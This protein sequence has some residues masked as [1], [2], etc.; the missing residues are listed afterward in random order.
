MSH[1]SHDRTLPDHPATR[2]WM[3]ALVCAGFIAMVVNWFDI[4]TGFHA[5]GDEYGLAIPD[6]AFLISMFVAAYGLLHI[7]GGFLATRW[8]LRR[9]IAVGLTIEGIGAIGSASAGSFAQLVMW[10]ALAG[11]GASI[12]AAVGIAAVSIWFRERHHGLAL[13]ISSAAFSVGT[14]LGL[15]TWADITDA[16][17]WR[18]AVVISGALAL[19]VAALSLLFFR[20]PRGVD[21]LAGVRLTVASLKETL[22]NRSIWIFGFAFFGA[23]GSFLAASQLL[24]DYG[25][26]RAIGSSE[27]GFAAFLIGIAGVPGSIAAGWITDRYLSPRILFIAGATLEAVFLAAVPLSGPGTFWIPALGIGFMFNFTFAVWQ[28]VPGNL[29]IAPENIGT[30]IGLMLSLSAIGG[31]VLP[32]AFGLI[33]DHQSYRAAWIFL[34]VVSACTALLGALGRSRSR[35]FA[36][37]PTAARLGGSSA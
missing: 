21:S 3:L 6:V 16:T 8:G 25:D 5:I 15:Y 29:A 30:A 26:S 7:P 1:P 37:R 17:S 23:Y 35:R 18:T 28:T 33:T 20:T 31:F 19:V 2:W 13:G 9:T 24:S 34:G 10:R 14:A 32:W 4:S 22:G 36:V 11:A 12:F 27:V